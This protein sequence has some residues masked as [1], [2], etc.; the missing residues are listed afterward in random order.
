M[1]PTAT[2]SI[3]APAK[4]PKRCP[5]G[6]PTATANSAAGSTPVSYTHLRTDGQSLRRGSFHAVEVAPCELHDLV[7]KNEHGTR[8]ADHGDNEAERKGEPE[9]DFAEKT[10]HGHTKTV[11]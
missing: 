6:T 10:V 9:V 4:L 5:I 1:P 7:F 8:E 11:W 3:P 2:G